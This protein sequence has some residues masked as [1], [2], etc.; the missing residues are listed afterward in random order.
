MDGMNIQLTRD[1]MGR[2]QFLYIL[3]WQ[4]ITKNV[5]K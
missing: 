1:V 4:E 3:S 5:A 2:K